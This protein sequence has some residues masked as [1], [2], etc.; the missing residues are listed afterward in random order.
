MVVKYSIAINMTSSSSTKVKPTITCLQF[1]MDGKMRKVFKRRYE[2]AI[3]DAKDVLPQS[4]YF[5]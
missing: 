4:N 2:R 5:S 1:L 3:L